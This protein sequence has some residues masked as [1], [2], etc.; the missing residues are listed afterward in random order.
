MDEYRFDAQAVKNDV[1]RWIQNY[2][3]RESGC[4][5]KAV[6]GISGGKDS[7]VVAAL[8]VEAL[9]VHGVMG[10]LMPDGYQADYEDAVN[11]CRWLGIPY[12]S[13]D[14]GRATSAIG[15]ACTDALTA[16]SIQ[17]GHDEQGLPSLSLNFTDAEINLAPRIRMATLMYVAQTIPGGR[18]ANTCNLS[19]DWVG[20]ATL[21]GDSVG[22]F[23]PLSHLTVSE[24][25]AIGN[26]LALPEW[27]LEKVPSDGLSDMTDEEKLGVSYEAIDMWIRSGMGLPE[28][29][30]LIKELHAKNA[31]KMTYAMGMPA[32]NPDIPIHPAALAN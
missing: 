11:V 7:S 9:G 15:G 4:G 10:V 32:F 28:H 16:L 13:V 19:E 29:I 14:I 17:Q 23:S 25:L 5:Q 3:E 31:F 24:V 6:V 8:C 18:V 21:F 2:F 27:V 26:E 22:Q 12:V 30:S 1:I 20:Y